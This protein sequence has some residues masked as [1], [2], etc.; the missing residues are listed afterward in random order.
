MN[1][2]RRSIRTAILLTVAIVVHTALTI[3]IPGPTR[4]ATNAECDS[5]QFNDNS[6][7]ARSN[8]AAIS[9]PYANF[10]SGQI[11][12]VNYS[13]CWWN[14]LSNPTVSGSSAWVAI[15]GPGSSDIVQIGPI[16][17]SSA[18][19]VCGNGMD[20]DVVDWFYAWGVTGDIFKQPWPNN[21][22]RA[23][24]ATHT[25][26]VSLSNGT[27][28]FKIDSITKK[29]IGDSWRPWHA[30]RVQQAVE[31]FNEGD[32]LG[33]IASRHQT[34]RNAYYKVGTTSY[35]Q[36]G[37]VFRTGHCYPWGTWTTLDSRNFDA[38]TT[39]P[40]GNCG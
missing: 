15:E 8:Y 31:I 28:S 23:D 24:T 6:W 27:W 16:K 34:F 13:L 2:R 26:V 40:H 21:L 32:Q 12:Y 25:Y 10:V 7:I 11:N 35:Y 14:M 5:L 17:C 19:D 37:S 36:F 38:W 4:A 20:R 30:T 9:S 1:T 18:A 29:T 22:G 33:G 3:G 39:D